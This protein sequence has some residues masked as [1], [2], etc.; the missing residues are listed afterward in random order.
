MTSGSL[1]ADGFAS[2]ARGDVERAKRP[3]SVLVVVFTH[4]GDFLLLDRVHP[5]HFWQSVTG[6]LRPGETPRSAALRELREETGL[7]GGG[8][9]MDLHSTR[10]FP[11]KPAWRARY[12][13]GVCFNREHWFALPLPGR[14]LIRLA[15][16][17]HSDHRWLRA[18]DAA[19]LVGSW[20][21]R[22]AIR[23]IAS[24]CALC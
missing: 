18:E 19:R 7:C 8:A 17:E 10:L 1:G 23:L 22:D 21:N 20:T 9:L 14:R 11:I 5:P 15:A 24:R 2:A 13:P 4:A 6:S 16:D 3:I 12:R